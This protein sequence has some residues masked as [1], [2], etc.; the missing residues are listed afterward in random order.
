MKISELD[1]RY[2]Y[3]SA[4]RICGISPE[5]VRKRAARS[6]IRK[7]YAADGT[8]FV[9]L[10]DQEI[11]QIQKSVGLGRRSICPD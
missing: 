10:N 5:A 6:S 4:A 7:T 2:T 8:P 1:Y 11:N 3:Q 9:V